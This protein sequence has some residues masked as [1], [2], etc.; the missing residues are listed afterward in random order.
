MECNQEGRDAFK[1][2]I[3]GKSLEEIKSLIE[4]KYF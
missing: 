1:W 3:Q 4:E 2:F